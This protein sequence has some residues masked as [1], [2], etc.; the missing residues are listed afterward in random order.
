MNITIN[1][2]GRK[3]WTITD[4]EIIYGKKEIPLSTI[5][6]ICHTPPIKF[7]GAQGSDIATSNTLAP[8]NKSK[9]AI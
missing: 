1:P 4:T 6:G 5:C 7:P 2:R 8:D 3:Q 9:P